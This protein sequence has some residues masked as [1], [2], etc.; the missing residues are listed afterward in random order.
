MNIV[1]HNVRLMEYNKK[2]VQFKQKTENII[3]IIENKPWVLNRNLIT[4]LNDLCIKIYSNF[5]CET[6]KEIIKKIKK[7][8]EE[9]LPITTKERV[10]WYKKK[11]SEEK[12]DPIDLAKNFDKLGLEQADVKD[13]LTLCKEIASHGKFVAQFLTENFNKLGFLEDINNCIEPNR[14]SLCK[15]ILSQGE[16]TAQALAE[17]FDKL[18]FDEADF[19]DRLFLCKE[20]T[21]QGDRAA[22]ALAENFDKLGLEQADVGARLSV[23]KEIVSQGEWAAQTLAENF[24]K[25]GLEQADIG[26]R[27]SL[28]KEIAS[29]GE[30][31]AQVLAENFDRFGF[32]ENINN[33]VGKNRLSLCKEIAL[34]GEWAAQGL[35]KNFDKL[36]LGQADVS[37]R[38]SLFK[39]IVLQGEWA[40]KALAENF[41]RI[42]L[43]QADVG[44]RLFV[45]K[46][47]V[48]QGEWAAQALAKSFDK[49]GLNQADVRDCLFLCIKI[50]SQGDRAAKVLV[51]NFDMLGLDQ[52]DVR[53]RLSL[54]KVISQSLVEKD[55]LIKNFE[56]L[57]FLEDI[58]HCFMQDRLSLCKEISLQGEWAAY[59][60]V[61]NFEKLGFLEGI[62]SCVVQDRLSLCEGIASLG[63]W[64]AL[65]LAENFD[66]LGLDQADVKDRMSLCKRI[67]SQDKWAA[68]SLARN[69]DKLGL[70]QADVKD[71]L[72]LCKMIALRS[73]WSAKTLV[74]NFDK[75]GLDQADV[76]DR[77]SLCKVI[78]AQGRFEA[79]EALVENFDKLGFLEEINNGLDQLSLCKEIVLQGEWAA[80]SLARNFD[81]LG[82]DQADVRDRLS[83]CKEMAS[84]GEQAAG[85][86]A[87]NFDKFGLDR[88]NVNDCLSLCRRIASQSEQVARNLALKIT[89]LKFTQSQKTL[90]LLELLT[91]YNH[92]DVADLN[93]FP[94]LKILRPIL[95][96]QDL[97]QISFQI[98]LTALDNKKREEKLKKILEGIGQENRLTE[99][100]S[101]VDEEGEEL[102]EFLNSINQDKGLQGQLKAIIKEKTV[103][104]RFLDPIIQKA[105]NEKSIIVQEQLYQLA[106]F[107]TGAFCEE[108]DKLYSDVFTEVFNRITEFRDPIARY[109]LMRELSL[110]TADDLKKFQA[111]L[112][113][114]N[115]NLKNCAVWTWI[116][117]SRI[118]E[119]GCKEDKIETL[120]E[121]IKKNRSFTAGSR[122]NSLVGCLLQIIEETPYTEEQMMII[123]GKLQTIL[124]GN[125]A[126]VIENEL[127]A[128][129][130]ILFLFGKE[131]LVQGLIEKK[132]L[133]HIFQ[134]KFKELFDIGQ[135]TDLS[136]RYQET[137]G[138]F[139]NPMTL[140][141]YLGSVNKL[142]SEKKE[143]VLE[144]LNSYVRAVLVG[145]F[146]D[147]RYEKE[148]S[149]HLKII[150]EGRNGME[151]IWKSSK[152][153]QMISVA[154]DS[155]AAKVNYKEVFATKILTDKHLDIEKF[156]RLVAYLQN[157]E[158]EKRKP[159]TLDEHFEELAI[160]LC[161][162]E[163][164]I[165]EFLKTKEKLCVSLGEFENDLEDLRKQK[166]T[167]GKYIISE[168]DDAC[169]LIEIGTEIQGSCQR[170]NGDPD[171][172]KCLV[173][174]LMN[175]EGRPIVVKNKE[176]RLVARS[177]LRLM[178]DDKNTPVLLQERIYSNFKDA[179]IED[180]INQ[181][182]VEKAKEMSIPLVAKET[183]QEKLYEGTVKHL[184][185]LAP[186]LYSDAS[187][188]VKNQ[189]FE[190][191]D[192]R[193]L[194]DPSP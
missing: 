177:W 155:S 82:L 50:A 46:E 3:Q 15:E 176:G 103:F 161:K 96:K 102:E 145:N 124:N 192:C 142:S 72:S 45:C 8:S 174:Y 141:T 80:L 147:V 91:L 95:I 114:G 184:G 187:G 16:W 167:S 38:L 129:K 106:A 170:V 79:K 109:S 35:A 125:Q 59:A 185:G 94:Y 86:L 11:I 120:I 146:P 30:W 33:C 24:D 101:V 181:W 119:L 115:K 131:K 81:K 73:K 88:A 64:V 99:F 71:R 20:I 13:R 48:L 63:E 179:A 18:G 68:L 150:F 104:S 14:L 127:N 154:A 43:D 133:S 159:Q 37:D 118:K 55:S 140:F 157:S 4:K 164:S 5:G 188:G 85:Y 183:S 2:I 175:G 193:V 42:G 178:C 44:D 151:S 148:R 112:K 156:P 89:T 160:H 75:L 67:A 180:A 166:S 66:K 169:D 105:F 26:D 190:T 113:I 98:A 60:L 143:K 23:C 28:C 189:P 128:L 29:Q 165:E 21:S 149:P 158:V 34:Q 41:D 136:K 182:A 25:L 130:N 62:N 83:L 117:L 107:C 84:Q 121:M 32:L 65:G 137:F 93:P 134:D 90:I 77:L 52:A 51:E 69:F 92:L 173:S 58:N 153:E 168:S 12:V 97:S 39:E 87:E 61:I 7:V 31:T 78:A 100:G 36:G 139:R 171:L 70:D 57:G 194:Y 135:V 10:D 172:N 186:Y 22:K 163:I 122:A 110:M 54:C 27:L 116:V 9:K 19:R 1:D 123:I 17:N 49:L 56:K 6:S 162:G 144:V 132:E 76:R 111:L 191:F 138:S 53:D 47:I 152:P 126:K 108:E 74:E 40:A